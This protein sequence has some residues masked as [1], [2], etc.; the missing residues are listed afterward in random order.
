MPSTYAKIR[1][2]SDAFG[3]RN[4]C[5]VV[6]LTIACDVPYADAH[7]T[8]KRCGRR[9]RCGAYPKQYK[10]A[11]D[12]LGF[13]F[14]DITDRF[15]SAKTLRTLEPKLRKR[16][17]N[18]RAIVQVRGHVAAWDGEKIQDWSAN[19]K[20]RI[21]QIWAVV[22][23]GE[24][25]DWS[26]IPKTAPQPMPCATRPQKTKRQRWTYRRVAEVAATCTTKYQLSK[27]YPGAYAAAYRNGWLNDLM[28]TRVAQPLAIIF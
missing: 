10:K 1:S 6:A 2:E 11:A 19:S 14:V 21:C 17:P 12:K 18:Q 5:T 4:D 8:M 25:V 27:Q 7:A 9:N 15:T 22:P 16:L 20:R 3:E 23:E 24:N 13:T 28:P 26:M